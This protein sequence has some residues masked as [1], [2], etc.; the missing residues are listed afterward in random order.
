MS[1]QRQPVRSLKQYKG[2]RDDQL[3]LEEEEVTDENILPM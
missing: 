2:L 1:M 3:E